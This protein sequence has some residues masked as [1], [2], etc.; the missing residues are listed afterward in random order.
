MRDVAIAKAEFS[1]NEKAVTKIQN[2]QVRPCM[3]S[4]LTNQVRPS[5][6]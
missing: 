6:V 1:P 3:T 5:C 2:F 4:S